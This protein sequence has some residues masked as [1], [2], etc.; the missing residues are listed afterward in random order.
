MI[1]PHSAGIRDIRVRDYTGDSQPQA[2]FENKPGVIC[3]RK[4]KKTFYKRLKFLGEKLFVHFWNFFW[5][6]HSFIESFFLAGK[7][8]VKRLEVVRPPIP[9]FSGE[10]CGQKSPPLG[11]QPRTGW[12][13]PAG[14]P[15]LSAILLPGSPAN[16]RPRP[17]PS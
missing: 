3:S 14:V 13:S 4:G 16:G 6:R 1:K 8:R 12:Q 15:Q 11:P 2:F 5:R 9:S 7:K 10:A 17:G